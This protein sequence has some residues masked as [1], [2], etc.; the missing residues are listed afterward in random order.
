MVFNKWLLLRETFPARDGD[1]ELCTRF[2]GASRISKTGMK[3][4]L[5][6]QSSNEAEMEN[7]WHRMRRAER[8]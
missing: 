3:T 1:H 5:T 8:L 2:S 6:L 4:V 7:L